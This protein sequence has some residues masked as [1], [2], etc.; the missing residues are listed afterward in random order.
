L[1]QVACLS[2]EPTRFALQDTHALIKFLSAM[3]TKYSPTD[4]CCLVAVARFDQIGLLKIRAAM[5][6]QSFPFERL[7]I[8]GCHR[9]KFFGC[10][11]IAR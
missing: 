8:F 6:D 2:D 5:V 7:I 10:A 9:Q 3:K 11:D 4:A 1:R